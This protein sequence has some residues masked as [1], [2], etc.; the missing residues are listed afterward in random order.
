M[1]GVCNAAALFALFLV[2]SPAA[3]QETSGA[4][5]AKEFA[6]PA[7]TQLAQSAGEM[8]G[9]VAALCEAPG[10]A[11][12]EAARTAFAETAEDWGRASVL[13]FGPLATD[14][15]FERIFFWPDPRGIALRQ[16][17]KL[18][19]EKDES[20]A[21]PEGIAQ[22]SAALQGLPALEFALFGSGAEELTTQPDSFRCRYAA[23][24]A[25]N[26]AEIAIHALAEWQTDTDFPK[27]F[28]TP[29]ESSE[30]YRSQAEVDGEIVKALAT[31]FQYVRAAELLPPLGESAETANGKRGP[32]WRSGLTFAL[33]AA[34][35]EGARDLLEFAGYA[36]TLP[37][38]GR[39]V[40]D[41][42]NFELDNA[43]RALEE[44]EKPAELA[45]GDEADRGR[46]GFV[47]LALDHA[48]HLVSEKL[49]AALGLTMGFNALD[50]D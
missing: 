13:R 24:V 8:T 48:G 9:A 43:L 1:R 30:P 11:A 19:A 33:M 26:I 40:A 28:A 46:L 35:V 41:S 23:A 25:G 5:V 6:R 36:D 42:I 38:D 4:R 47:N 45:F 32:L 21:T 15:R 44:I 27:A 16:V 50:G 39:W 37:E 17:Q 29:G 18:L 10:D 3:A 31:V 20:A 49:S 14:N 2:T 7:L 22:K 34:Q 12:L